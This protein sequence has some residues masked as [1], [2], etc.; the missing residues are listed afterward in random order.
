MISGSN[1]SSSI[2]NKSSNGNDMGNS[3]KNIEGEWYK[4][5]IIVVID[6]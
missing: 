6:R 3:N 1:N 5:V 4:S 2:V